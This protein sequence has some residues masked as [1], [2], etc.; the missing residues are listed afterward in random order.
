MDWLKKILFDKLLDPIWKFLDG[1]KTTSGVV[2]TLLLVLLQIL[3][4]GEGGGMASDLKRLL[5]VVVMHTGVNPWITA[6]EALTLIGIVHKVFK[7][8]KEAK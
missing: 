1:K 5:D 8:G 3:G 7:Y 6:A 4:G 2:A